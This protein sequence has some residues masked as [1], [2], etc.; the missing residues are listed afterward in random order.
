MGL[1]SVAAF[2]TLTASGNAVDTQ[3][4]VIGSKTYTFLATLVDADGNVHI[5]ADAEASLANL[6]AAINL[7]VSAGET[8]VAGTD[9]A[10]TMTE[11][12]EANASAKTATTL[13]ATA[14]A[15]G[16]IGNLVPTTETQTNMAWGA[17]LLE[18]GTGAGITDAL[19]DIRENSGFS[20]NAGVIDK[21][22][23]IE[24]A[25]GT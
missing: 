3:V 7:D 12:T 8:G 16:T 14:D 22:R 18:G 1:T 15:L 9:Y 20:I 17:A 5:G 10:A 21:L 11:N 2:G 19:E 4:V 6:Y 25:C 13:V 24:I 23:E